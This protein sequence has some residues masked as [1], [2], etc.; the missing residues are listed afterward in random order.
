MTLPAAV[1]IDLGGLAFST[2][3]ALTLADDDPLAANTL[4]NQNRVGLQNNASLRSDG[5]TL[6]IV[7]PPISWTEITSS[8]SIETK[9]S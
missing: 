3:S 2:P 1:T 4:T 9:E 6:T 8:R 5:I 7:L